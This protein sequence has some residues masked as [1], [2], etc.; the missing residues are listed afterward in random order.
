MKKRPLMC[1]LAA[2]VG[3][4]CLAAGG[5]AARTLLAEAAEMAVITHPQNSD[6][7]RLLVR[8]DMPRVLEGSALDFACVSF[9]ADCEA[10]E[11]A[12]WFQAFAVSTEWSDET[13]GWSM[14]W[15]NPGGDW[16]SALSALGT[17]ETGTGK[18]VYLDVTDFANGWLKQ[19]SGNFGIIVKVSGPFL[20]NFSP[21]EL[22]TPT[23]TILY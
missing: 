18:T 17:S 21:D 8:F 6:E 11:G 7:A 3:S 2:A 15:E 13:V 10:E 9:R 19:P 16:D 23:M 22:R 4:L 1:L 20:G 5:A 12:V 14:P